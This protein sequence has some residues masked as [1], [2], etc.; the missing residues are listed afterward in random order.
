MLTIRKASASSLAAAVVLAA[1]AACGSK[2]AP[3]GAA[4]SPTPAASPTPSASATATPHSPSQSPSA[5]PAPTTKVLSWRVT[6]QWHWPND[7]AHPGKVRHAQAVPP[8]PRLIAI[9]VG[10]HPRD[11]GDRPYNR[12][13]FTFTTGFPSYSFQF[14]NPLV[15]DNGQTIPMDGVGSLKVTFRDAQAHKASGSTSVTAQPPAHTELSRMIS[16]APAGDFEG[17]L[18]YGIGVGWPIPHS[19]PQLVV[20][21]SEEEI[22]SAQG[23]HRYIV[24]FDV[25]AT[26][27]PT[28]GQS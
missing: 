13:S 12:M 25:D 5:A 16:W 18:S 3:A 4:G 15:G 1:L 7:V 22:I 11:P 24:A 19:N 17:V 9:R 21:A 2:P 10:D 20:R 28:A 8:V 6:Y 27:P 26:A 14:V 23:G